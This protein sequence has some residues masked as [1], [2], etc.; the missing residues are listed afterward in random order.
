MRG[1]KRTNAGRPKVL[2]EWQRLAVGLECEVAFETIAKTKQ[3]AEIDRIIG[4]SD[5]KDV[6]AK[7]RA[8]PVAERAAWGRSEAGRIHHDDVELERHA[9]VGSNPDD[10][11]PAAKIISVPKRRPQGARQT[12]IANIATKWTSDLGRNVSKS[13]VRKCWEEARELTLRLDADDNLPD[14][15]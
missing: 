2:N 7:I 8:V 6:I 15:L 12:I 4:R 3:Q 5:Y 11:N 9:M 13:T 1:G 14:H 10:G